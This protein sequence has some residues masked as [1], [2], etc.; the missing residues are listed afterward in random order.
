MNNLDTQGRVVVYGVLGAI[1]V[2]L[3]VVFTTW[4]HAPRMLNDGQYSMIFMGT[5]PIGWVIGVITGYNRIVANDI[6]DKSQ[7]AGNIGCGLMIGGFLLAAF[8]GPIAISLL[9]SPIG[10]LVDLLK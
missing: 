6:K 7:N 2:S 9:L 5:C 3:L 10:L 1:G 4:L 8:L